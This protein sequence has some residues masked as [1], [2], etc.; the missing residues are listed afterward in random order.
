MTDSTPSNN[1][2]VV[3]SK[4]RQILAFSNLYEEYNAWSTDSGNTPKLCVMHVL[5]VIYSSMMAMNIWSLYDHSYSPL[6]ISRTLAGIQ[7][8]LIYF[9][10]YNRKELINNSIRQLQQL[11]DERT[12]CNLNELF[13]VFSLWIKVIQI[14]WI[15]G[16]ASSP[17]S[18]EIYYGA[19]AKCSQIASKFIKGF[20]L[21]AAFFIVPMALCPIS[22]SIFGF[23]AKEQWL[24]LTDLRFGS[25]NWIGFKIFCWRY[26]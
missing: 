3:L 22:Y 25:H 10:L 13:F 12:F 21:V 5:W 9:S 11:I 6:H 4:C 23:P 19:E 16:C 2:F 15:A 17:A 20:A 7:L 18:Y 26:L 24:T 14:W 8:H 1:R